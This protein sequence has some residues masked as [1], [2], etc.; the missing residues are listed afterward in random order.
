MLDF[1][2]ERL[3]ERTSMAGLVLIGAGVAFL[4]LKPIA[5]LAALIA[6]G[7]GIWTFFKEE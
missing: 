4:V 3:S 6:I 7:Y 1:I 5:N 2:K